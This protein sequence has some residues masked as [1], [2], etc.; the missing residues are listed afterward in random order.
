MSSWTER[1]LCRLFPYRNIIID[2]KL[3]LRRYFLTPRRWPLRL[4]LH[5]IYLP[6]PDRDLHDHPWDFRTIVLKGGYQEMV[7]KDGVEYT[8]TWWRWRRGFRPAEH[9]HRILSVLPNTWTLL[10]VR[11]ARRT[12]GFWPSRWET[13]QEGR[14]WPTQRF[15]FVPWREYLGTPDAPDSP[16]D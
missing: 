4:F 7:R 11:R 14:V 3:Y 13:L 2:G 8:T 16:E 1:L 15:Y 5:R 12:W 6:D 9:T 10:L